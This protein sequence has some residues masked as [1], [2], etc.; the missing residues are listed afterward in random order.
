MS[1]PRDLPYAFNSSLFMAKSSSNLIS[2]VSCVTLRFGCVSCNIEVEHAPVVDGAE[3]DFSIEAVE[4]E[5][6]STEE[7]AVKGGESSM[8]E[9]EV[10]PGR[11]GLLGGDKSV[12]EA[13]RGG[14]L[15]AG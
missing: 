9:P 15:S 14:L 11:G 4:A 7:F 2:F 3:E 6:L 1:H 10:K 13:R 8:E 12:A 5:D